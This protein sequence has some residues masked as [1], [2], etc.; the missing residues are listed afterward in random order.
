MDA[1]HSH[2]LYDVFHCT[3][4]QFLRQS[5]HGKGKKSRIMSNKEV[6]IIIF[7]TNR[8]KLIIVQTIILPSTKCDDLKVMI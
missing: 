4:W 6:C 5:I 1:L 7:I 8:Q 2:N 3:F